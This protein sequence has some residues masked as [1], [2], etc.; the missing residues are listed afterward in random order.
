MNA[1][2]T[3]IGTWYDASVTLPEKEGYYLVK[4]MGLGVVTAVAL[5][6]KYA[7]E[8]SKW[9]VSGHKVGD[10]IICWTELPPEPTAILRIKGIIHA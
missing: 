5:Y 1:P 10:Q 8:L 3:I 2:Y 4:Y 6:N 7:D 9:T